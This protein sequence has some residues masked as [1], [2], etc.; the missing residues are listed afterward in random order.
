LGG[1]GHWWRAT[2]T[3][4][5]PGTVH[6][7]WSGA[8]VDA[9][10]Y[11]PGGDWL[12]ARVPAM[13][14]HLD[15]AELPEPADPSAAGAAVVRRAVQRVGVPTFG[16]TETPY[17]DLLPIILAQRITAREAA[18]QW[19][20]LCRALGSPAPGPLP[21]L[22]LPPTPD[23]LAGRPVWWFHPLGIESSR[24]RA[25]ITA[26]RHAEHLWRLD[27]DRPQQ[28]SAWLQRLPGIGA[29]SAAGV[30]QVSFGDADAVITGDYW[31]PHLVTYALVGRPRGSDAEMLDLLAPWAPQ[32]A[33]VVRLLGRAGHGVVRF[34]PGKRVL[35]M[36]RW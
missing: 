26:A 28:A 3:P 19:A 36:E 1:P 6:V 18:R 8:G 4:D 15:R 25:L 20:R 35:P 14:G 11:G 31:L 17:H 5:G 16:R 2:L 34:G 21:R 12:L 33:R 27:P 13:L 23:A 10:G 7:C 30:A 22:L 32:R 9:T 29:W 24:A